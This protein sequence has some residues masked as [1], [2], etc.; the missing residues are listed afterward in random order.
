MS[1]I[2]YLQESLLS[3]SI[4]IKVYHGDNYGLKDINNNYRAMFLENSNQ[5]E[6]PGIY[7][8]DN[9][10][11][12]KDYGKYVVSTIV[13]KNK[14]IPSREPLIDYVDP[15]PVI[16]V[17]YDLSRECLEDVFYFISDYSEVSTPEE[18]NRRHFE[19]AVELL[20]DD[21]ARNVLTTL[22]ELCTNKKLFV[23][24]WVEH[25]G[26]YG[27]YDKQHNDET[28]YALLHNDAPVVP[29]KDDEE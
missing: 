1:I 28:W 29:I 12:A 13:D 10:N 6:G 8:S 16:Q 15:E 3:E 19:E 18:L 7:F 17:L 4:M 26:I 23:D 21:Q 2:K 20:L 5:Q 24:S 14:L 25:T 9:I 11:T 22:G 27:T